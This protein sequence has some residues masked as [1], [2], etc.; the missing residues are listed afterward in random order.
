MR[1]VEPLRTGRLETVLE[2]ILGELRNTVGGDLD[3]DLALLAA[4]YRP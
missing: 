3:D 2:E 4:E 1:V